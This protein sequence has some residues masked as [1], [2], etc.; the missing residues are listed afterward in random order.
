[1]ELGNEARIIFE[2]TRPAA[3]Y[4]PRTSGWGLASKGFVRGPPLNR[5]WAVLVVGRREKLA[6]QE[7]WPKIAAFALKETP[8]R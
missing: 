2:L 3:S 8:I 1:M 7:T 6:A 5:Y 4:M